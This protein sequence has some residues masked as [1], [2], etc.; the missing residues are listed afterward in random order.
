MSF[1]ARLR[2]ERKRLGLDQAEFATRTGTDVPKLSRCENDERELRGPQLVRTA[3]A[4]VDILYVLIGRRTEGPWLDDRA[5]RLIAAFAEL[6]PEMQ[7]VVA[8][9]M[10]DVVEESRERGRTKS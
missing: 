4:G 1:G 6:S 3:E 7:E 8:K 2:E 10:D 5:R 9:F